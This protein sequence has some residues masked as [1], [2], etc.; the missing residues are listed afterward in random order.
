MKEPKE[1][2]ATPDLFAR[3]IYIPAKVLAPSFPAESRVVDV[4]QMSVADFRGDDVYSETEEYFVVNGDKQDI[5]KLTPGIN[6]LYL[7][8]IKGEAKQIFKKR[9]LYRVHYKD[10]PDD[11]PG[12]KAINY[13]GMLHIM[14]PYGDE[15]SFFLPE[16]GVPNEEF[17]I[18]LN[19]ANQ[20]NPEIIEFTRLGKKDYIN[21]APAISAIEKNLG[22]PIQPWK[23]LLGIIADY[24]ERPLS[25]AQLA[26]M[27]VNVKIIRDK[28]DLLIKEFNLDKLDAY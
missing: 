8:R 27:L 6:I 7:I 12:A 19:Q 16:H 2:K 17:S 14:G 5:V 22:Q 4:E 13:L 28:A 21:I 20:V 10:V 26:K 3:K 11:Y 1:K 15:G 18:I 9:V 24:P 23:K 25:R